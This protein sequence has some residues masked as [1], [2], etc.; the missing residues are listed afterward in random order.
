MISVVIGQCLVVG[1]MLGVGLVWALARG[2]QLTLVGFAIAPVFIGVT[3]LQ[4]KLVGR[5][6]L[7]NKRAREEVAKCYYES[8]SKIRGIRSMGFENAFRVQ[9]EKASDLTL[10][11]GIRGAFVEGCSFGIASSL[12]YL[13]EAVLFYAG[14][15]FIAK[16]T[17]TYLQMVEVLNLVVFTV[18]IGSQLMHF[19]MCSLA[20]PR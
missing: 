8:V 12:I 2:W 18:T 13:A 17:Y 10:D 14:A 6:E 1:T 11:A 19:S 16:G 9:F 20:P 5:C 4:A 3:M 7:R 15:I